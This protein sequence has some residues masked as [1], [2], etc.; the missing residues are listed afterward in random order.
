MSSSAFDLVVWDASSI[1]TMDSTRPSVQAVAVKNDRI[2]AIGKKADIFRGCGPSTTI[3]AV[4]GKTVIPGF[5][6]AHPHM[7]RSGLRKLGG[8][9]LDGCT[10][11]G[12]ILEV[13]RNAVARTPRGEWIV[14]MPMG[15]APLSYCYRPEDLNDG[16]FPTR[17]DLDLVAP[18]HPVY[19]RAPWGW[20]SHQPYPSV[21]N[22]CALQIA[23][24]TRSTTMPPKVE[25]LTDERG[26]PTGVF[27]ERYRAPV[28]EYT[29]FACVPRF[30]YEDR[31]QSVRLASADY[32]AVGTTAAYEG[33]GLTP[34]LLD[35]YY[36]VHS[37]GELNVRMQIPLS[38]PTAAF[39]NRKIA[40][41]INHWADKLRGRGS[42]DDILRVDGI[43]VDIGDP[44]NAG[45]IGKSYPYEQWAGHF[46][47][48]LSHDR[49]VEIGILA[50][51]L[52]IRLSCCAPYGLDR[53][54]AAY[55]AIDEE[56]SI[57]GRRWVVM[58]VT[59][60]NQD[61][62]RRM[63]KLGVIA[64]V[65]PNFMYMAGDR[66]NLDKMGRDGTPIRQLLDQGIPVA[67]S[68]DNVPHS[69]LFAMWEAL[70]RWDNDGKR[71]LG[72]SDLTREEVLTMSTKTGHLLSWQED[73]RGSLTV[74]NLA[75]F[76]ILSENPVTCDLTALKDIAVE[77]TF[78]GGKQVY[79]SGRI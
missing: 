26:D 43:C 32:N 51:K 48:A 2:A 55:E 6:D 61:Q 56:I 4:N 53:L 10:S 20:W 62:L 73:N 72:Q 19:I 35:A 50:A 7:D 65:N 79:A 33:H 30:T 36:H 31:I 18:D 63:K 60:A 38:I 40:E 12:A 28:L 52:D 15:T 69:M 37:R 46:Q 13:V 16:R 34:T 24:V 17:K 47:Q 27:L 23:G 58:H 74:G 78:L 44:Q 45:I 68:T 29:I 9:S 67:L 14:T 77:A 66:F 49:F 22:T 42:G 70:A 57:G 5:F 3:R 71:Q 75:D 54:L 11:I 64:T 76:V 39:D 21:A 1:L 41:I 59:E 8:L 25:M